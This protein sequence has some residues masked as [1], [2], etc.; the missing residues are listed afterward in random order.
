MGSA[1]T[2]PDA[3]Q[4]TQPPAAPV[5][6]SSMAAGQPSHAAEVGSSS[7]APTSSGSGVEGD[8]SWQA[9][10]AGSG[11]LRAGEELDKVGQ[12]AAALK[13]YQAGLEIVLPALACA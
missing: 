3:S 7:T 10:V 13:Q 6:G 11:I 9:A 1:V 12:H 2:T 5:S 4:G 8:P